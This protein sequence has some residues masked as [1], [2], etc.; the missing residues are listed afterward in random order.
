MSHNHWLL[1]LSLYLHAF[2]AACAE[3]AQL[4]IDARDL[5]LGFGGPLYLHDALFAC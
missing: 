4:S 2:L 3:G 5:P 1:A